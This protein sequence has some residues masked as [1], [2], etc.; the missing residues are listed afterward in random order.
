MPETKNLFI[1]TIDLFFHKK[2]EDYSS[3]EQKKKQS[4]IDNTTNEY[5]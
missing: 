4:R 3:S 1:H 5:R 2:D